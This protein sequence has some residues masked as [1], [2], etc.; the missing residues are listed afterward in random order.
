MPRCM[1]LLLMLGQVFTDATS[2]VGLGAAPVMP[3]RSV[4]V[5]ALTGH[6]SARFLRHD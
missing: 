1:M 6:S 2:V 3:W 4:Q 5:A